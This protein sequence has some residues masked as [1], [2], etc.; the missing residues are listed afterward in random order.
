VEVDIPH[1]QSPI[2]DRRFPT[3][4]DGWYGLLIPLLKMIVEKCG[5]LKRIDRRF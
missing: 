3:I 5:L 1:P 4:K 2:H